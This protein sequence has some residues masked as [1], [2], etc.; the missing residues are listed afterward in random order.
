M[1]QEWVGKRQ[2][3]RTSVQLRAQMRFDSERPPVECTI[4]DI[5]L[6]GA[7]LTVPD[8]GPYPD[9]F[10]I[11]IPA[12]SET[13]W[14]RVRWREDLQLGVEFPKGRK[15]EDGVAP[16]VMSRL[17]A[18]EARA[19]NEIASDP[20]RDWSSQIGALEERLAALEDANAAARA[21]G[22]GEEGSQALGS[23]HTDA[24]LGLSQN[25]P[26]E[27]AW[28][29]AIL[30]RTAHI[31][32]RCAALEAETGR[33]RR[34]LDSLDTGLA[35][36]ARRIENLAQGADGGLAAARQTDA[37]PPEN[38]SDHAP[39]PDMG[40]IQSMETRIGSLETAVQDLRGSLQG[41]ILLLSAQI[42][43]SASKS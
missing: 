10:D 30:D 39:P 8:A 26:P 16:A 38:R 35:D 20:G 11:Y 19:T 1:R 37:G 31:E 6:T 23:L 42:A 24:S 43:R 12:R 14:A 17:T 3:P 29:E 40:A 32:S 41:L 21:S 33:E 36:Q 4:N 2:A 34:R 9:E 13:K 7:R 25:S 15:G 5:S 18:L 28:L 27:N 22:G